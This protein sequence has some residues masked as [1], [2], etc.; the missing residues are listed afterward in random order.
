MDGSD[1]SSPEASGVPMAFGNAVHA[2]DFAA[3]FKSR[4]DSLQTDREK[5]QVLKDLGGMIDEGED[6]DSDILK[7]QTACAD[8]L[9]FKEYIEILRVKYGGK[10]HV[11]DYFFQNLLEETDLDISLEED[12]RLDN[13][14]LDKKIQAALAS[15]ENED[16]HGFEKI[17]N[18]IL[19][20]EKLESFNFSMKIYDGLTFDSI[21]EDPL[22]RPELERILKMLKKPDGLARC[23][24]EMPSGLLF[25]GDPGVGKTQ[26]AKIL[27]SMAAVPFVQVNGTDFLDKY[28]GVSPARVSALF[29][30]LKVAMY[31]KDAP[32]AIVY[33]DEIDSVGANRNQMQSESVNK[34]TLLS[35]LGALDGYL[36]NPNILTIASTNA[37]KDDLDPALARR[38]PEH[39]HF[40]MPDLKMR[41]KIIRFEIRRREMLSGRKM[42]FQDS[43]SIKDFACLTDQKSGSDIRNIFNLFASRRYAGNKRVIKPHDVLDAIITH[44]MGH[45]VTVPRRKQDLLFT[46]R[47]EAGHVI[48]GL[49]YEHLAYNKF[50]FSTILPRANAAGLAA[51]YN[52]QKYAPRSFSKLEAEIV[53]TLGGRAAEEIYYGPSAGLSSG[54]SSD[55]ESVS[56]T[57]NDMMFKWGMSKTLGALNMSFFTSSGNVFDALDNDTKRQVFLE[58]RQLQA[59]C[60]QKAK[61][62]IAG[63]HDETDMIAQLLMDEKTV[64]RDRLLAKTQIRPHMLRRKKLDVL[65]SAFVEEPSPDL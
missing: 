28:A 60:Y 63:L 44:D 65:D 46:A 54:P 53:M 16:P 61:Q 26:R 12:E 13:A 38:F 1:N 19:K 39:M 50:L 5:L 47:H 4:I 33:I 10:D 64:L 20:D 59:S 22:I 18:R 2:V 23:H 52:P 51:F 8:S 14:D 55:I 57:I 42:P 31:V 43:V 37:E 35:L 7:L 11:V 58:M 3:Y 62:I 27:S 34:D 9:E 48:T 29:K 6:L 17:V 30:A 32:S 40:P 15:S 41:E 25:T 56:D 45:R 21:V 24:G 36:D 49:Y